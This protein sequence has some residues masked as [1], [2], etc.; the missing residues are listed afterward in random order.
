MMKQMQKATFTMEAVELRTIETRI[1]EHMR[2]A[3]QNILAVGR[4]LNEAKEKKLVPHGEWENWV[5]EQTGMSARSAQRVMQAARE[6]P[7]TSSLA[8]LPISKLSAL[9]ALPAGEREDFAD[10]VGA[11][12]ITSRQLEDAIQARKILEG[13]VRTLTREKAEIGAD[14]QKKLE[15]AVA[16]SVRD[17]LRDKEKEI[18]RLQ[19]ETDR[20]IREM[21]DKEREAAA[22]ETEEATAALCEELETLRDEIERRAE[23]E[24]A[25]KEQLLKLRGEMARGGIGA[26][27]AGLTPSA[28][29]AAVEHFIGRAAALPHMDLSGISDRERIEYL[30]SVRTVRDWCDRAEQALSAVRAV[31]E[32][33]LDA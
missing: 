26:Q 10:A 17:A 7:E 22:A 21:V 20:K 29:R 9:L 28:V 23:A 25:A 15:A 32:V 13:R 33:S 24:Q 14:Y 1:G 18:E 12:R 4:C 19:E 3:Y 30:E 6:V 27:A 2:G 16:V 5:R 8:S 31:W 11:E